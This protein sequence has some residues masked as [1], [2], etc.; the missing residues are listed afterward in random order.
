MSVSIDDCFNLDSI[1]Y[2]SLYTIETSYITKLVCK[3][4][5]FNQVY[6]HI[7]NLGYDLFLIAGTCGITE[8]EARRQ[9]LEKEIIAVLNHFLFFEPEEVKERYEDIFNAYEEC[10]YSEDETLYQ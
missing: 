9:L 2:K 3:Y 4:R 6:V 7:G 5:D 8:R 10:L 1:D